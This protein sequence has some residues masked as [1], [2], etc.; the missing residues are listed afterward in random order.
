MS[1]RR[2]ARTSLINKTGV[3]LAVAVAMLCCPWA[4]STA[5][6][7]VGDTLAVVTV[8][9]LSPSGIGIGIAVD[10]AY[11]A[12]LYYTN[13]GS[14]LLH[15]MTA[16]GV[17]ISSTPMT[18]AATGNPISFGAIA[19]DNSRQLLWGGTDRDDAQPVD[20]YQIDPTT[21]VATYQFSAVSV[22][23]GFS[24]GLAYDGIGDTLWVSDDISNNI[25][26][27][28]ADG[29]YLGTL[30][31]AN[32]AGGTLS[33]ISGV[34]V[35]K[36]DLL[37]LGRNGWGEIVQVK[38]SDGS[39][40]ASFAT[41]GGRDEDL[42]C[43]VV[44]F[45][46]KTAVWSKDAYDDTVT[47]LEVEA[48]TCACGGG[49]GIGE[50]KPGTPFTPDPTGNG[51]AVAYNGAGLLYY[52]RYPDTNIYQVTTLGVS[53]GPIANPGR[54]QCGSLEWDPTTGDLWCG[55]YD[56]S[57]DVF[58]VNPITG[59]AT[60]QL[61]YHGGIVGFAFREQ[62]KIEVAALIIPDELGGVIHARYI[63]AHL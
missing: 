27:F 13:T 37:Y 63:V 50:I 52:T 2:R 7:A 25:D 9:N 20:I 19:W 38:K 21:G 33:D 51:R 10:C 42:E 23:F 35:G 4:L 62:G 12:N 11:P 5:G 53:L 8:P 15:K 34:L 17:H 60:A 44:S 45:P 56:G 18:D 36:G 57:S 40:I 6:A 30:T 29:V 3:G 43:D 41:V 59:F 31:P 22:T 16:T 24:D 48:G 1:G 49:G 58:T 46:G 26:H 14:D 39:F 47:A 54:V 61:F 32:A 28:Q 55:S